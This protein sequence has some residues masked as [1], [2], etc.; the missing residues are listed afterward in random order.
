MTNSCKDRETPD[1]SFLT[2]RT[3]LLVFA[4]IAFLLL[5]YGFSYHFDIQVDQLDSDQ[6]T[7]KFVKPLFAP[8]RLTKSKV[9]LNN[10][11]IFLK[12][13]GVLDYKHPVW[14]IELEP[15]SYLEIE[16]IQYGVVPSGFKEM[17]RPEPLIRGEIYLVTG[18]AAGGYGGNEFTLAPIKPATSSPS[19][20]RKTTPPAT[21]TMP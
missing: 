20:T 13:S 18:S 10:F 9:L 11:S 8:P 6:P 7:F 5:S 16:E 17:V 19:P 1:R 21:N 12:H 3:R 14:R 2:P 4:G 15:G